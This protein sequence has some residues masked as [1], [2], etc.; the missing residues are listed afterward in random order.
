MAEKRLRTKP[1]HVEA[2]HEL[3]DDPMDD[4]IEAL[5]TNTMPTNTKG[6]EASRPHVQDPKEQFIRNA[7]KEPLYQG[8]KVS[9][10][11]ALLSILN[12]QATFGWSDASV[13]AL[14][15]LMQKILPDGNCMPDS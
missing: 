6:G 13:S 8:A 7:C 15:Q 2:S 9:K 5:V 14:F 12:L 4:M 1:V 11:R 10:L 3:L